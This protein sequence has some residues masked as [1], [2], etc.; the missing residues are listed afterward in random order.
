MKY[1][2]PILATTL[3]FVLVESA[4]AQQFGHHLD[5]LKGPLDNVTIRESVIGMDESVYIWGSGKGAID[6]DG[7]ASSGQGGEQ[8]LTEWKTILAKYDKHGKLTWFKIIYHTADLWH[9]NGV[10]SMAI[11]PHG[12]LY[13][14]GKGEDSFDFDG[15]NITGQGGEIYFERDEIFIAKYN[16]QGWLS[17]VIQ[18]T[19]TE[20]IGVDNSKNLKIQTGP[21]DD[22]FVFG[23]LGKGTVDFDGTTKTGQ[24]GELTIPT[25]G[26]YTFLAKYNGI[27]AL[28]WVKR[29]RIN[30]LFNYQELSVSN[31]N[32]PFIA[33]K[34]SGPIDLDGPHITGQGGEMILDYD[35]LILAKFDTY[36]SFLW[37][38]KTASSSGFVN[39]LS[40][41]ASPDGAV[42]V[43]AD[44]L[45][46][47]DFD[48]PLTTGQGGEIQGG[49]DFAD[50]W[51][52]SILAR[53]E[54]DGTFG[55]VKLI[56]LNL[57]DSIPSIQAGS[58]GVYIAGDF[59]ETMDLDGPDL[60]HP[61]S[62][63]TTS[64]GTSSAFVAKYLHD[65]S[66]NWAMVGSEM[67]TSRSL[68]LTEPTEHLVYNGIFKNSFLFEGSTVGSQDDNWE[69]FIAKIDPTTLVGPG[70]PYSLT[71][72]PL[73]EAESHVF[74]HPEDIVASLVDSQG[75]EMPVESAIFTAVTA[76]EELEDE[77][78]MD[79]CQFLGLP[80]LLDEETNGR[81]YTIHM[82]VT[83]R[84]GEI[85]E[86]Q[87]P[88]HII[89][90]GM[91]E[92]EQ[93]ETAFEA[94]VC[95]ENETGKAQSKDD[96][97][98]LTR[99]AGLDPVSR[100][101]PALTAY[102]NPFNPQ[103]TV[104][105][106]LPSTQHVRV[107]VYDMLGRQVAL[108]HNGML[109]ANQSHSFTFDAA[110]LRSGAYLV[111]VQ[112]ESFVQSRRISLVK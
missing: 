65:G 10:H 6:L 39:V 71:P 50:I 111:R 54:A 68:A 33:S 59:R 31:N 36:G 40:V 83:D 35:Q 5:W 13:L 7:P 69:Q 112:G 24:G 109:D 14:V 66:F 64:I 8:F 30:D 102:P 57:G 89:R 46:W 107:A 2:R 32:E 75:D 17:W 61:G 18:T 3:L 96:Q 43:V 28:Q 92:A 85:G 26:F 94:V 110:K 63:A 37:A 62:S 97:L 11:G 82:A 51:T 58:S 25:G 4:T 70:P 53:Y 76:D 67:S 91:E 87:V 78:L 90:E 38:R 100:K 105:L 79:G 55:W 98:N 22:V 1:L 16:A 41:D 86:W 73:Y 72:I 108:I 20:G 77:L 34:Q 15:P 106:S 45:E 52:Y 42:Y 29:I 99:H 27:S 104:S 60:D 44:I 84:Y 49:E 74:I 101:E 95:S 48:G 9:L 103:T 81:V 23:G 47:I 88:V 21:Y 80:A 12:D 93:D 56:K 19:S